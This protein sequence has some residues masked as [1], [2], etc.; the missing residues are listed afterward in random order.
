MMRSLKPRSDS[1]K[2]EIQATVVVYTLKAT[3]Q[4]KLSSLFN[5]A[6]WS[7][8]ARYDFAIQSGQHKVLAPLDKQ[9]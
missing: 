6:N 4:S 2:A 5:G 7:M 9:M 3:Q 1:N 8:N